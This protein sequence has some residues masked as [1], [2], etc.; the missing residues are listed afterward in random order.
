[1]ISKPEYLSALTAF[2]NKHGEN[3]NNLQEWMRHLYNMEGRRRTRRFNS[4][5][6]TLPRSLGRKLKDVEKQQ[7]HICWNPRLHWVYGTPVM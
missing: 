4:H 7:K 1:M 2:A 6:F 5:L 3:M